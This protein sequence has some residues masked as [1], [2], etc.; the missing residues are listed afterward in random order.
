[1]DKNKDINIFM[2]C[3]NKR[4]FM[5]I[6][7]VII[8]KSDIK[9]VDIKDIDIT[10]FEMSNKTI[11]YEFKK[12]YCE[13]KNVFSA[14]IKSTYYILIKD[15][16]IFKLM[17]TIFDCDKDNVLMEYDIFNKKCLKEKIKN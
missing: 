12:K 15:T 13:H 17:F 8:K 14:G 11:N 16:I 3:D 10:N 7:Q 5:F 9:N 6:A 4:I 2:D 1:M